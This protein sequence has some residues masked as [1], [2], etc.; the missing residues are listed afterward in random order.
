MCR[1]VTALDVVEA[2]PVNITLSNI[3]SH[4]QTED[5]Q[6]IISPEL[7]ESR[8][9]CLHS[10]PPSGPGTDFSFLAFDRSQ[11]IVQT[12]H[13]INQL[14]LTAPTHIDYRKATSIFQDW[15]RYE[16]GLHSLRVQGD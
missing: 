13:D 11:R 14:Y 2:L 3:I 8:H 6:R 12:P 4:L 16:G 9:A 5:I 15:I 1:R 7:T 10:F